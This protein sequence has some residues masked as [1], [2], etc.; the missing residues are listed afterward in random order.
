VH[1]IFP[2]VSNLIYALNM[3]VLQ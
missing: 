3:Q 2:G 1:T